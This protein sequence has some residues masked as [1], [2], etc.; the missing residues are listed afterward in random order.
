MKTK[1][2]AKF[3]GIV[4]SLVFLI[5]NAQAQICNENMEKTAPDSRFVNNLDGTV[6]DKRTGLIWKQCHEG[7]TT[8]NTAC[9]TGSDTPYTW[10]QAIAQVAIV[11]SQNFAGANTWRLPNI[12]ELASLV[13]RACYDPAINEK[14][15]PHTALTSNG[16]Y[17]SSTPDA[18]RTNPTTLEKDYAW[19]VKF[20][21]GAI[22]GTTAGQSKTDGTISR[23]RLVRSPD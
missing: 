10:Q 14:F 18:N 8:V 12:K 20:V 3:T 1:M 15:F 2:I 21:G 16:R 4:V 11:N 23:V 5:P 9:D 6:T 19:H 17:W 22:S 7:K 13:E